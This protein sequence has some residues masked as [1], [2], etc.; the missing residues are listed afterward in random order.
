[1]AQLESK[2]ELHCTDAATAHAEYKQMILVL[3]YHTAPNCKP[4]SE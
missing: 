4:V 1:M 3:T 2:S